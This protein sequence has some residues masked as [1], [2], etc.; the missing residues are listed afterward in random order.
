MEKVFLKQKR[1]IHCFK[2]HSPMTRILCYVI[3]IVMKDN[4]KYILKMY[5]LNDWNDKT[6]LI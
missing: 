2:L 6:H 4:G 3:H 5:A 1:C